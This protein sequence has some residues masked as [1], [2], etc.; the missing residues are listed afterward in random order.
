VKWP[1]F[2]FSTSTAERNQFM[3]SQLKF[4]EIL[5][6]PN[7]RKKHL[8]HRQKA[9][10]TH[11]VLDPIL[12]DANAKRCHAAKLATTTITNRQLNGLLVVGRRQTRIEKASLHPSSERQGHAGCGGEGRRLALTMG[13][14]AN[15]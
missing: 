8:L 4:S 12:A 7:R 6:I 9:A 10:S 13:Y 14:F 3:L 11:N 1:A 15:D 5:G 2:D